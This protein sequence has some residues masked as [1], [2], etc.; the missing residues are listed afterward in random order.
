MQPSNQ[1][2]AVNESAGTHVERPGR[3]FIVGLA[4]VTVLGLFILATFIL[5]FVK[6]ATSITPSPTMTATM[7]DTATAAAAGT[8]TAT[9]APPTLA[10]LPPVAPVGTSAATLSST[11]SGTAN[12][13]VAATM[14]ATVGATMVNN[15]VSTAAATANSF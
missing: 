10:A 9:F 2:P 4:G 15:A 11:T 13:S 5:F 8:L 12:A 6:N 1:P 14:G 3:L 7:N